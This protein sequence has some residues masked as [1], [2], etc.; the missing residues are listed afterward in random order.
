MNILAIDPSLTATGIATSLP[1]FDANQTNLWMIRPKHRRGPERLI[2][3]RK[4]VEEWV[5]TADLIVIEG[6]SHGSKYHAHALGELGG[7][8]RVM[9]HEWEVPVAQMSPNSLKKLATGKGNSPK[10]AVLAAAIHR[11]QYQGHDHNEADALWLLEAVMQYYRRS[12][13][14][15]PKT[16]LKALEAIEW[17]AI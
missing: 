1:F 16:H 14:K 6:Y 10:D 12:S 8:L 2:W 7:V 4:R 13:I 15:L 5:R 9:F 3:I 11:L 17:P